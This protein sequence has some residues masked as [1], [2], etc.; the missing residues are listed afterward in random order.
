MD[1]YRI[2]CPEPHHTPTIV[3]REPGS[4]DFHSSRPPSRLE[5]PTEEPQ[6]L[7]DQFGES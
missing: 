7:E 6:N 2:C 4:H 1:E 3:W 5:H